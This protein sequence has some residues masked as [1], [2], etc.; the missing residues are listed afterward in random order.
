M[1]ADI[2]EPGGT[3]QGIAQG[4]QDDITIRVR[5]ESAVVR[6]VYAAQHQ[7]ATGL[8]SVCIKSLPDSHAGLRCPR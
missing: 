3:Q 7:L 8:K 6:D 5:F 1:P 4:M 2:A